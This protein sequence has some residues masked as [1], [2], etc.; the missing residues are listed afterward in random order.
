MNNIG[1]DVLVF[2]YEKDIKIKLPFFF[3]E[4]GVCFSFL[5]VDMPSFAEFWASYGMHALH[6]SAQLAGRYYTGAR[7]MR[8]VCDICTVF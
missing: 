5:L 4:W 8:F 6:T 1:E 7:F 2:I 3:Y